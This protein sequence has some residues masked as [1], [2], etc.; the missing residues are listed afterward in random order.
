MVISRQN[1]EWE[2]SKQP[3]TAGELWRRALRARSLAR[4]LSN[5]EDVARLMEYVAELEARAMQ[6]EAPEAGNA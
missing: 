3:E 1:L 4:T 2:M 5:S 6:L